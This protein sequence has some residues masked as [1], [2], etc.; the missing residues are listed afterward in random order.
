M[1]RRNFLFVLVP[2][3][4]IVATFVFSACGKEIIHAHPNNSDGR[5]NNENDTLT[6][7]D[8]LAFTQAEQDYGSTIHKIADLYLLYSGF[9]FA[10]MDDPSFSVEHLNDDQLWQGVNK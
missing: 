10:D 7:V 3:F 1:I 8:S 9:Y 2:V 5:C 6:V 4:L